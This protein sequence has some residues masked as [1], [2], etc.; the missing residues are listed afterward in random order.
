[1]GRIALQDFE[2]GVKEKIEVIKQANQPSQL[3]FMAPQP[4]IQACMYCHETRL[5][6]RRH[7]WRHQRQPLPLGEIQAAAAPAKRESL[8]THLVALLLVAISGWFLLNLLRQRWI[9]LGE[10]NAALDH[11]ESR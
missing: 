7:P 2:N 3:R 8:I 10:T 4:V 5:Q 11:A 1:M 9:T 6:S